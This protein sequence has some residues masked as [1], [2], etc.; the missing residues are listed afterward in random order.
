M[1]KKPNRR[2]VVKQG[3]IAPERS[4]ADEVSRDT[5]GYAERSPVDEDRG[6]RLADA[7]RA[8]AEAGLPGA[9][10]PDTEEPAGEPS[11]VEAWR[12]EEA[13][14][15]DTTGDRVAARRDVEKLRSKRST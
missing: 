4:D 15:T 11:D 1:S 3:G 10:V 2:S 5:Y 14:R 8:A 9:A 12:D 13:R 6:K 7:D